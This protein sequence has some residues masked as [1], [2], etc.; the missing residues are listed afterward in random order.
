VI[1][2]ADVPTI[3]IS[4]LFG[5]S[6]SEKESVAHEMEKALRG[7]GFFYAANH[8]VDVQ[9]LQDI[10]NEF[11]RTMTDDEK[12][13]LAIRAYNKNNQ[14]VRNGYYMAMKG[15]KAVESFCYLNPSFTPQHLMIRTGAP[16]HEVNDWPDEA[17]HPGF[18]AF[19]EEYFWQVFDVSVALMRGIA[20][21]LGK[22]EDFFDSEMSRG[23]TLAA[24]S[25][26]RYPYLESYP[27]VKTAPDGTRLSFE[28]HL[29]V[30]LITVLYQTVVQN[31]Q[32]ETPAGWLDLPTSDRDFL[33]NAGTYL[34]YLTNDFLPAPNHR[35]KFINAERL[36]LPFFF[37]FGN[38][39]A[40][41]TFVPDG[42]P[43]PERGLSPVWQY[44]QY[45]RS[46]LREL[47]DK[48]GQT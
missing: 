20:L 26:I 6:Q 45:L 12:F 16:M 17:A 37:H 29:D 11:H 24:V 35:V 19:C 32:V 1:Q 4:P 21:A 39:S 30:S 43:V 40:M 36:S 33:I 2:I 13:D 14:H 48:N 31:L 8:G 42:V 34:A 22:P 38:N 9:R 41:E 27:P 47:I 46:S 15:K 3:D 18:R 5:D 23:D 7:S 44:G 10:V 25:L 28:D